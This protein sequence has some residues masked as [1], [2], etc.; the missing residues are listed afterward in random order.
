[1]TLQESF[2]VG[3]KLANVPFVQN[4]DTFKVEKVLKKIQVYDD[5]K[6]KF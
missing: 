4:Y 1:M 5:K 6:L 2:V 3:E